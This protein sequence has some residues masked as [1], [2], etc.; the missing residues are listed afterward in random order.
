MDQFIMVKVT[1]HGINDYQLVSLQHYTS[2]FLVHLEENCNFI[3]I[4]VDA[5]DNYF[6][7]D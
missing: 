6:N 1:V 4:A 5:L 3:S 7:Q 2:S